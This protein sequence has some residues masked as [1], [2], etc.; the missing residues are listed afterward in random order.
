[1]DEQRYD[2]LEE[3]E[4]KLKEV[5]ALRSNTALTPEQIDEEE[6]YL[7]IVIQKIWKGM[8]PIQTECSK[9]VLDRLFPWQK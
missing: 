6:T 3:F 9:E 5:L 1:M 2:R 4:E 7:W 8:G